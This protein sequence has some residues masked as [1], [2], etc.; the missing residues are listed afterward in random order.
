MTRYARLKGV[1]P[2]IASK[3]VREKRQ[4]IAR[5][6]LSLNADVRHAWAAPTGGLAVSLYR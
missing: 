5:P 6:S 3:S 4:A 1:L 2:G